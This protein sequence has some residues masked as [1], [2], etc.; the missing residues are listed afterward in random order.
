VLWDGPEAPRMLTA[1]YTHSPSLSESDASDSTRPRT[2]SKRG[3][4]ER[5]RVWWLPLDVTD[6]RRFKKWPMQ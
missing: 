2:A 4:P 5:P 6:D 1:V 3:I